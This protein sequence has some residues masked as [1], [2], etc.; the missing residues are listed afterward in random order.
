M[1]LPDDK[2]EFSALFAPEPTAEETPPAPSGTPWKVLVVDDEP[3][4]HAVLR[5]AMQDMVVEGQRLQLFDAHSAEEAKQVLAAH[6]DIAL[7]LLDVVMETAQAGLELVRHV[8]R[9]TGNSMV[10]IVLVTGQPGYAPQRDVVANYEIDGYR[11]KSELTADR[12]FVSV[13]AGLRAYKNLHD[14]AEQRTE[15]ENYRQH[16]E[17][18]VAD[19][20]RELALAKNAAEAANLAKTQF[21][22]NMSH[23]I[24]TPMNAVLGLTHLLH[25]GAT[26]QQIERLQKISEAGRHL[27]SIINDI[28]DL[29]KIEAGKLCLEHDNFALGSVLDHVQSLISNTAQSKGLSIEVDSGDLPM[30]LRGDVTRLRQALLNYASNAV[31]FTDHGKVALRCK[32]L[33]DKGDTLL[34]RFEVED[35]GIGIAPDEL[36]RLFHAFEQVDASTSRRYGGTGL[37]LVITRRLVELMGGTVGAESNPGAGSR[38]WFIVPLQRGHGISP[39]VEKLEESAEALLQRNH[40]GARVLLAEDNPINSEVALELLHGAGLEVTVAFDGQDALEKAQAM[41][42]DLILM[43]LQMPRMNGLESARAILALPQSAGTPI[44]AMTANAFD[45][46]RRACLAAGFS[47]FIAK[48]VDPDALYAA[49]LHWIPARDAVAAA[50]QAPLPAA[51]PLASD[52]NAATEQEL[53][54][55]AKLPGVD[56]TQG[57][58]VLR[59][60]VAKYLD[61]MRQFILGHANDMDALQASLARGEVREAAAL[62]HALKGVAATLGA[63]RIA[64][65]ARELEQAAHS[66]AISDAALRPHLD[67]IRA[68]FTAIAAVL[69]PAAVERRVEPAAAVDPRKLNNVLNSLEAALAQGDLSAAELLKQHGGLLRAALG[70]EFESLARQVAEF[71]FEQA[72]AV[73]H[74]ARHRS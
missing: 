43:D 26:P 52:A 66:A 12:I 15:L 61:L 37:G 63:R 20:T 62:A 54:R 9:E 27:M 67:A 22:A 74:V 36:G 33:E 29:S 64:E 2:D 47:D 28:L 23:E 21:L 51:A 73:L 39:A 46:D 38:F 44:L 7:I 70:G 57:L 48:P 40:R 1:S 35:S 19:R 6:P 65:V 50:P 24:R 8:R 45:E 69:P 25:A 60:K 68:E 59:G 16:L 31:K 72:R 17:Q 71:D 53:A 10:R 11:L 34:A 14:I 55:L 56:V 13:Y 18:L 4:I 58:L 42:H 30:W 49:L 3:D 32:L 41:R 5:L